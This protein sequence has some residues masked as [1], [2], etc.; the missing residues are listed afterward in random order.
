L[1]SVIIKKSAA[2]AL[3]EKAISN[4]QFQKSMLKVQNHKSKVKTIIRT[5]HNLII[6]TRHELVL[7]FES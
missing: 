3:T 7:A 6:L 4:K 5:G 1:S 2:L